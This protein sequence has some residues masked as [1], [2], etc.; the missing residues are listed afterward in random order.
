MSATASLIPVTI[1][2]GF[3]G[4]GKTTLLSNLLKGSDLRRLAILVNEFGEVSIDGALLRTDDARENDRNDRHVEI[5][6]LN[7]GLVAYG[8]DDQFFPAMLAIR[9]RR[10]HID[11]VLIETSGLALPTAVM[12][13]LQSPALCGDFVLDAT[14]A[15]VDTPLLLSGGFAAAQG[16][17]VAVLFERQL[18]Y[19]DIVVLNKIDDL[20]EPVLLQAETQVRNIAPDVRFLELAWGAKLDVRLTLG[21]RL[22]SASAGTRDPHHGPVR[23]TPTGDSQPPANQMRFDG[24][25]HFGQPAHVHGLATHKHFH[26]H[27]PGWQ[28]FVLRSGEPQQADKLRLALQQV[29]QCEPILRLKG[30]ATANGEQLSKSQHLLVQGV[31]SRIKVGCLTGAGA[32]ANPKAELVFI[33]YHPSRSRIVELLD[34]MTG[35]RW[36]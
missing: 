4:S 13:A 18:E 5:H 8:E 31:R 21:L 36:R 3:L 15:V 1:V 9:A 22:H 23:Y 7:N 19:A 14:L 29:V 25:S 11:H 10:N 27:D 33:G 30:F 26:E 17:S 16:E 32:E 20:D 12:A 34:R 6:E 28:S 35:T 24:H 2:T